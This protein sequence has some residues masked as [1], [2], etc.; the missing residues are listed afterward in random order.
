MNRGPGTWTD[1][2][3]RD[4][5]HQ[6]RLLRQK[7]PM[8]SAVDRGCNVEN[9]ERPTETVP[10]AV[11]RFACGIC[12]LGARLSVCRGQVWVGAGVEFVYR[13]LPYQASRQHQTRGP[14]EHGP[15][16]HGRDDLHTRF[17][18]YVLQRIH[19]LLPKER[20]HVFAALWQ[21]SNVGTEETNR[22]HTCGCDAVCVRYLLNRSTVVRVYGPGDRCWD[23][24]VLSCGWK[25][26]ST[27]SLPKG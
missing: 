22:N 24:L 3:R 7:E 17:G 18:C 11:M 20:I 1:G 26:L 13:T 19:L 9:P 2:P 25:T 14:T 5:L 27:G 21:R 12:W 6:V 8:W 4:D 10:V 16:D 23:S 15:M